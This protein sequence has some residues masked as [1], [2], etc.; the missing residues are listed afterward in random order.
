M[1]T[2]GLESL[3]FDDFKAHPFLLQQVNADMSPTHAVT[4]L[5]R[6]QSGVL[7]AHYL[8]ECVTIAFESARV[9]SGAQIHYGLDMSVMTWLADAG[10]WPSLSMAQRA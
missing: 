7:L 5:C 2:S 3:P 1:I 4:T 9:V 8:H 10:P 6:N